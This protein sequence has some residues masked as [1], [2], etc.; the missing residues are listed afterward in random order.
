MRR[1]LCED[2]VEL[3]LDALKK[4]QW[5]YVV[6]TLR[7]A[8][9]FVGSG[10]CPPSCIR[11][12]AY[13]GLASSLIFGRRAGR[14]FVPTVMS[15]TDKPRAY[16]SRLQPLSAKRPRLAIS[17][18][19]RVADR[20]CRN[21]YDVEPTPVRYPGIVCEASGSVLDSPQSSDPPISRPA[22]ACGSRSGSQKKT[23]EFY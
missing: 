2:A 22:R 11:R 6:A 3:L 1:S 9:T 8:W 14:Q 12:D 16:W 23:R 17:R 19:P 21:V 18:S 10:G 5:E 4:H 15:D 13:R 20:R 7:F